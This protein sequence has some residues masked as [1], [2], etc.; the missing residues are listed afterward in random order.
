MTVKKL[1]A[2]SRVGVLAVGVLVGLLLLDALIVFWGLR[3]VSEHTTVPAF[4]Y[5][6]TLLMFI[7]FRVL[8]GKGLFAP[9]DRRSV[10]AGVR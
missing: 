10:Q 3:V 7:G 8:C 4:S 6:E 9:A 1:I 2:H 5:T